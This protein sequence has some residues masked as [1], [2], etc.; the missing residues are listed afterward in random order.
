MTPAA[1]KKAARKKTAKKKTARKI[2]KAVSK[3]S[4]KTAKKSSKKSSRK[5][6]GKKTAS[7]AARAI[8]VPAGPG[9]ELFEE[10]TERLRRENRGVTPG[11]MMSSPGIRWNKKV[12]AFYYSEQMVFR[13]GKEFDPPTAGIKNWKPLNPFKNKGPLPGWFVLPYSEKSRWNDLADQALAN[14]RG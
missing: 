2:K 3:S 5:T 10:I 12:F 14:M 7:S 11:P 6:S 1:R 8:R 13:L 9:A 4:Q